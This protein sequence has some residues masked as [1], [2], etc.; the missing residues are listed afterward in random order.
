MQ[1]FFLNPATFINDLQTCF[2]SSACTFFPSDETNVLYQASLVILH[3]RWRGDPIDS[4]WTFSRIGVARQRVREISLSIFFLPW[5]VAPDGRVSS[6]RFSTAGHKSRPPVGFNMPCETIRPLEETGHNGLYR[7]TTCWQPKIE[8]D[9]GRGDLHKYPRSS[10]PSC[11]GPP[12]P[13]NY[14]ATP[15]AA[16]TAR[17]RFRAPR[18]LIGRWRVLGSIVNRTA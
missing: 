5:N 2:P 12:K 16:G 4:R 11:H 8:R 1:T 9:T 18:P 13:A 10:L 6:A 17:P 14:P 3:P 7:A 15:V